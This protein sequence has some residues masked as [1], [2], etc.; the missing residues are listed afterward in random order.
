M[1]T[2]PKD[3]TVE[4]LPKKNFRQAR[5]IDRTDVQKI[6]WTP[7]TG[8]WDHP[9]TDW[10]GIKKPLAEMYDRGRCFT[11]TWG[12]IR[13]AQ[14][15]IDALYTELTVRRDTDIGEARETP[16]EAERKSV[17]LSDDELREKAMTANGSDA[18]RALWEGDIAGFPS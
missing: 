17:G 1:T 6:L 14:E 18:F 4:L 5:E 9:F 7:W 11:I 15:A 3:I 12:Q 16:T 2:E 13:S 10:K 8:L